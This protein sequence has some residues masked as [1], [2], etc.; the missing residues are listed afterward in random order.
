[1]IVNQQTIEKED[2]CVIVKELSVL[3]ISKDM[4]TVTMVS[5][6]EAVRKTSFSTKQLY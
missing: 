6:I 3:N 5:T 2:E 4:P 1:V